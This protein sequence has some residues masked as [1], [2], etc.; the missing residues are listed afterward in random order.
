MT[1]Q[2]RHFIEFSIR[3]LNTSKETSNDIIYN[4][5]QRKITSMVKK[6]Q[7]KSEDTLKE[8]Q[9]R[10]EEV[11]SLREKMIREYSELQKEIERKTRRLRRFE[12]EELS[13]VVKEIDF[14][15]Y[16][17]RFSVEAIQLLSGLFG[18]AKAEREMIKN[19]IVKK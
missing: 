8:G 7:E 4:E 14:K 10:D 11:Q 13:R 6:K 16:L 18:Y 3:V 19:G 5:A 2:E 17:G 15:N 12:E 9:S 1:E